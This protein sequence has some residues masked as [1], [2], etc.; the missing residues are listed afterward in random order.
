MNNFD[1][2]FFPLDR[3]SWANLNAAITAATLFSDYVYLA[4]GFFQFAFLH[5]RSEIVNAPK[6]H[7]PLA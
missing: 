7:P 5:R 4:H 3:F 2:P 6:A 1:I